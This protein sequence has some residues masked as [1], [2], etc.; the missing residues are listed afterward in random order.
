MW[1]LLGRRLLVSGRLG[2][3]CQGSCFLIFVFICS[4]LSLSSPNFALL[5]VL[6]AHR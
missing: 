4:D 5:S 6:S 1:S 2:A 3:L